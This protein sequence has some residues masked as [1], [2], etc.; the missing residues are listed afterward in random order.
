MSIPVETNRV[1]RWGHSLAIRVPAKLAR[2]AALTE[3]ASVAL[4]VED[5]RLC[6]KVLVAE[7]AS[8]DLASLLAGIREDNR[9][10]EIDF[11]GPVGAEQL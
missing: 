9:H 4:T 10:D 8:Y 7:G 1:G 5:G 6:A 11:G 2:E 3:G